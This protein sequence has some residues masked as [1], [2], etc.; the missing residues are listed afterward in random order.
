MKIVCRKI[1]PSETDDDVKKRHVEYV[2]WLKSMAET[3]I[4]YGNRLTNKDCAVYFGLS[5][6]FLFD[7]FK[8]QFHIPTSTTTD[9]G[10]SVGFA[11]D[12]GIVLQF[13]GLDSIGTPYFDTA[14]ISAYPHEKEYLFFKGE[15]NITDVY[16]RGE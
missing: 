4:F 13:V 12:N 9:R 16:I 15:L 10:Q 3:L 2:N 1:K 6:M 5:G 14:S 7:Q 8:A 11:K